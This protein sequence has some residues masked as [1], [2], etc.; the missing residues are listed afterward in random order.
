MKL[1]LNGKSNYF[2]VQSP[3]IDQFHVN[4][5]YECTFQPKIEDVPLSEH[6][7]ISKELMVNW[8][9]EI[10]EKEILEKYNRNKYEQENIIKEEDEEDINF[11]EFFDFMEL[12]NLPLPTPLDKDIYPKSSE[13]IDVKD[14]NVDNNILEKSNKSTDDKSKNNSIKIDKCLF[15]IKSEKK[16]EPR[17]DY[18]IKNIK[19]YIIKNLKILGNQLI[20]NCNFPKKLKRLKLFSPSYKYFTGNSN[21]KENKIFLNFSVE[22]IF[23]YPEGKI[24]KNDNRLQRQN[25]EIIKNFIEYIDEKYPEEIPDNFQKL[26]NFFNMT[27]QDAIILFY[28]SNQF[29]DFSTSRKTRFL[30]NQFIKAKGF[31]LL[32]KNGFLKLIKNNGKNFGYK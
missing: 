18:A 31:S 26:K 9:N 23:S 7:K 21:D 30:D 29:N 12:D 22:K 25:K 1:S 5:S 10:M 19:V 13:P 8:P 3:I 11:P 16:I 17:I 14:K 4:S 28:D 20:K 32:E 27:F 2:F 6:Q 24:Q 15:G